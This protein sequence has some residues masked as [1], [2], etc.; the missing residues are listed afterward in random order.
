MMKYFYKNENER[1]LKE[2][3]V[4]DE[5]GKERERLIEKENEEKIKKKLGKK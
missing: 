5:W 2:L 3:G 4:K 1:V